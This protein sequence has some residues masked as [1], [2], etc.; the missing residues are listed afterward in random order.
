M[1]CM[2]HLR[3]VGSGSYRHRTKYQPSTHTIH[4]KQEQKLD[5]GLGIHKQGQTLEQIKRRKELHILLRWIHQRYL[6]IFGEALC[7][8]TLSTPH[9]EL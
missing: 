6:E 8:K 3:R 4:E 7:Y 1:A 5:Q 2:N 9:N